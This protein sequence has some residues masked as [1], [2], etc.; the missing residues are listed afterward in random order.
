MKPDGAF[1]DLSMISFNHYYGAVG[2]WMCRTIAGID[3]READGT[4]QYGQIIG[5]ICKRKKN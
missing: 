5:W 2:G 4:M 1:Q 3:T